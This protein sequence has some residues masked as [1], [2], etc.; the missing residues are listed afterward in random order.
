[1][2]SFDYSRVADLCDSFYAYDQDVPF[3]VGLARDAQGPVLELMACTGRIS[4]PILRHGV[5]LTC[6]DRAPSMLAVLQEKLGRLRNNC[7][8]VCAD[9]RSIPLDGAFDLVLLP[10]QGFSELV[11]DRE[12]R[13]VLEEVR[14]VLL[15]R[16]RFVC[17]LHNPRVRLRTVDGSWRSHLA[18]ESIPSRVITLVGRSRSRT[19]RS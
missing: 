15:P 17:T 7:R 18:C 8:L 4:I 16:G 6:L 9:A 11:D 2:A 13:E 1:M 12:R 10:F 14:R 19:A 5:P 3:F